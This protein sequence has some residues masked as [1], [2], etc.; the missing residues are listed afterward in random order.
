MELPNCRYV[1]YMGCVGKGV[2][3][4]KL[5]ISQMFMFGSYISGDH[6]STLIKRAAFRKVTSKKP[7]Y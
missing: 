2:S 4:D 3:R 5:M 7:L 6:E 1:E